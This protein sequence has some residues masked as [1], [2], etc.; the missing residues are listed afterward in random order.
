[1]KDGNNGDIC[2]AFVMRQHPKHFDAKFPMFALE[3][4]RE[5][6]EMLLSF[7]D[8]DCTFLQNMC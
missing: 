7:F 5:N 6:M 2:I 8:S 1:M 3:D 4:F